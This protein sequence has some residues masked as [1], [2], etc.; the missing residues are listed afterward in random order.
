MYTGGGP[1]ALKI[2]E[3]AAEKGVTQGAIYKALG[4]AGYNSKS[5]TNRHGELTPEG[6]EI[7]R[8]IYETAERIPSAAEQEKEAEENRASA[9]DQLREAEARREA[10]EREADN[11]REQLRNAEE[12]AERAAE[13]AEKWERL[14]IELQE[15]A[16]QERA[17]S[18][19]QLQAAHV[20]LSQQLAAF[21]RKENPIKRLFSGRKKETEE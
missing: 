6:L 1:E 4:R 16:A 20:L 15:K 19:Q 3:Y 14:Y 2:K 21:T 11:L 17:A 5:L 12:R 9:L 8:L 7:L 13:R 18:D 10:A